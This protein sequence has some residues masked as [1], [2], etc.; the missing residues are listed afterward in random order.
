MRARYLLCLSPFVALSCADVTSTGPAYVNEFS[1][2]A[3]SPDTAARANSTGP[4]PDPGLL[5]VELAAP[6]VHPASG[7]LLELEGPGIEAVRAPGLELYE[8]GAPGR[9][10]IIVAGTL[11]AGPLVQFRVPDRNRLSLYRVRVVQVTGE[12]YG[13]RDASEYRA[14]ITK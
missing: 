3:A 7:V 10:R 12:D 9:H 11:E 14:V 6:T 5:T 8:S 2:P 13:L 4:G 1:R